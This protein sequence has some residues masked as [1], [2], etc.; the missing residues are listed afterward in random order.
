MYTCY[1]AHPSK[2]TISSISKSPDQFRSHTLRTWENT[3]EIP[4]LQYPWKGVEIHGKS[5]DYH[6]KSW[7]FMEEKCFSM[8]S[9]LSMDKCLWTKHKDD[10]KTLEF[11]HGS[12]GVC[13]W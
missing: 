3:E 7:K 4:G 12:H 2:L 13:P 1:M 5:M 8:E 11:V 10:W 9:Q 6:G